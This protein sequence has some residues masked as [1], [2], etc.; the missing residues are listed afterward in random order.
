MAGNLD[1]N[2]LKNRSA[3]VESREFDEIH[4]SDCHHS[5]IY[6]LRHAKTIVVENTDTSL[7]FVAGSGNVVFRACKDLK[8]SMV[9]DKVRME[10]C[11]KCFVNVLTPNP[12]EVLENS[13]EIT[14]G[15]FNG[16][17]ALEGFEGP[18]LWDKPT[19]GIGSTTKIMEPT[20]FTPLVVPFGEETDGIKGALPAE[21]RRILAWR[22]RVGE[23][24]RQLV[25]ALCKR[26]PEAREEVE[27]RIAR[28]F[29][30]YMKESGNE[31]AIGQL[32]RIERF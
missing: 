31:E 29:A 23:E 24:R 16:T 3:V 10:T 27:T 17:E 32:S 30:D 13:N 4:I 25:L 15:P 26:F 8:I 19:V 6:I 9:C 28:S 12:P 18:G 11:K 21:F 14:L 5:Q 22:E 20:D 7:I 2:A 1:L